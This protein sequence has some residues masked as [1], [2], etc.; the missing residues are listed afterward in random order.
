LESRGLNGWELQPDVKLKEKQK[1]YQK[2]INI[3]QDRLQSKAAKVLEVEGT[4]AVRECLT[5]IW[6]ANAK[7]WPVLEKWMLGRSR[8][9]LNYVNVVGLVTEGQEAT[10][11]IS[12]VFLGY[13]V[14][15]RIKITFGTGSLSC[16]STA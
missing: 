6:V 12:Y 14:P 7:N 16:L 2:A 10:C 1:C 3:Q 11:H 15:M 4:M 5:E 9:P 8:E 13:W